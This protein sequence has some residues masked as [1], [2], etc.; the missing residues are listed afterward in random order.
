MKKLLYDGSIKIY[1]DNEIC[2]DGYTH[3]TIYRQGSLFDEKFLSKI[4]TGYMD[5]GK[6]LIRNFSALS[7][8]IHQ[9]LELLEEFMN[10]R[11]LKSGKS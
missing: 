2:A 1:A 8:Q 4:T 9:E 6:L 3:I 7:F 10:C 5:K 11:Y